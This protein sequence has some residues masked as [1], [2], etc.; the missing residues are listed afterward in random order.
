[1]IEAGAAVASALVCVLTLRGVTRYLAAPPHVRTNYRGRPVVATGGIVL[2]L[3]LVIGLAATQL[4]SRPSRVAVVMTLGGLSM[5]LLGYVDDVYGDRHAGGLLG[6]ARALLKGKFTTGML[7]AGGGAAVGVLSA[8]GLG[9]RGVWIVVAGAAIALSANLAN[10]LDLRPGRVIKVWLLCAIPVAMSTSTGAGAIVVCAVAGALA[11]FLVWE[12]REDVM[13]GDTGAGLVGSVLGVGA[14]TSVGRSGIIVVVTVL[15]ALTLLSEAV[16]FTRLIE[17]FPPLRWID[18]L[19][20]ASPDEV[21]R[22]APPATPSE[23]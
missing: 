18:E 13:L 17:A 23:T 5:A 6:H 4:S 14:A 12:L 21:R 19:G 15:L 16:S 9:W 22:A 1:M 8:W 7:K 2:T 3:A 20:R 10:L 11:V